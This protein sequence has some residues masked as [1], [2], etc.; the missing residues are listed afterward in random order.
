MGR[1]LGP[2]V[3]ANR[4]GF[5]QRGLSM[6]SSRLATRHDLHPVTVRYSWWAWLLAI[7]SAAVVGIVF[8]RWAISL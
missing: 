5:K 3:P 1:D 8:F 7:V 6:A 4:R 2:I